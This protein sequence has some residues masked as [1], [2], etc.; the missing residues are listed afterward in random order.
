MQTQPAQN[1][2]EN[3][4][5]LFNEQDSKQPAVDSDFRLARSVA[6]KCQWDEI[7]LAIRPGILKAGSGFN[8]NRIYYQRDTL[9]NNSRNS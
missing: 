9:C 3:L 6:L 5:N 2:T 4:F 7:K 1:K 8:L